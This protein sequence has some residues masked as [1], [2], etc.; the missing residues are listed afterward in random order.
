VIC[1]I[2]TWMCKRML[3]A[4]CGIFFFVKLHWSELVNSKTHGLIY[5]LC[6]F[7]PRYIKLPT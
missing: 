1:T 4:K 5:D 7:M 3:C 6:I 2:C